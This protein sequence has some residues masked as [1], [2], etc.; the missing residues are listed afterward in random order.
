M[1]NMLQL[2]LQRA[3]QFFILLW[4][5]EHWNVDTSF[6]VHCIRF[7]HSLK[8]G[9]WRFHI[10]CLKDWCIMCQL[11]VQCADSIG[12]FSTSEKSKT[13]EMFRSAISCISKGFVLLSSI[14]S[15]KLHVSHECL[16]S[17]INNDKVGHFQK[18]L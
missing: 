2:S 1:H 7:L 3:Y 9:K 5:H 11:S 15:P 12:F 16:S 4:K 17:C 10:L 18:T 6:L 13:C 14:G 8:F